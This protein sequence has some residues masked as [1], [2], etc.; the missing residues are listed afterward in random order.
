MR[1]TDQLLCQRNLPELMRSASGKSVKSPEDW[2]RRRE[3]IKEI[4]SRN[5]TGYPPGFPV[6]TRGQVTRVEEESY[7]GKAVTRD[8]LLEIRSDFASVSFPFRL[9]LPAHV[10]Q[11]P[12]FVY[13]SFTPAAADGLGE[14]I[15]DA[16]YGIASVCYQDMAPDY[17]D[18]HQ[19]GLGRFCTRNPYDSWGKLREWSWGASRILDYLL[20]Q[21]WADPGRIAVM[22]H[23]R[24][25]KT[26]LL[27]GAFDER[28]SLTVANE[29]G[30]GG[31]ALFRKKTGERMENLYGN[32]SRLWFA[33]NFFKY[34]E[35]ELPF[36]QHFLLALAAPRHLYVASA[37]GD[38]WAD[39]VS[40]FLGCA[41]AGPAYE[42]CQLPGLVA[43]DRLPKI[44]DVFHEG[45]VGYHL[46]RGTH[47]LSRYDWQQVIAYRNH[48]HI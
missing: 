29:S 36:D 5:L 38:G 17:D 30:A 1:E 41:A 47:Y 45:W 9:V 20:E 7:G 48:H 16:G 21:G 39:P 3:E 15:L 18:G 43:P 27:A 32:G 24:L 42:I 46:R 31:A 13:L 4:L 25:G 28:F 10:K 8:I 26:A 35:E 2:A 34:R 37:S 19:N 40:E 23:S 44:G 6:K 33:G 12:L 22:G 11:P 14:E